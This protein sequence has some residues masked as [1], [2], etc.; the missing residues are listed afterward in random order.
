ME[1]C[2]CLSSELVDPDFPVL[3]E[4]MAASASGRLSS[5]SWLLTRTNGVLAHLV[6]CR[7]PVPLPESREDLHSQAELPHQSFP[8]RGAG[9]GLRPLRRQAQPMRRLVRVET[10]GGRV[11]RRALTPDRQRVTARCKSLTLA[12]E[13]THKWRR[14]PR[15]V[16][17]SVVQ[18]LH[19]RGRWG[20]LLF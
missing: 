15:P 8:A 6:F 16:A 2:I 7:A 10:G 17:G 14:E 19:S 9:V 20:F 12:H 3:C 13:G 18:V 4:E 11:L 5:S 1:G